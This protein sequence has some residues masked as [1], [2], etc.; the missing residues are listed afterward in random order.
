MKMKRAERAYVIAPTS[1]GRRLTA[2]R[3]IRRRSVQSR[4]N[5]L[6][7]SLDTKGGSD[8]FFI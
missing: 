4:V 1:G 5:V 2:I 3:H 7:V 6:Y 8:Q